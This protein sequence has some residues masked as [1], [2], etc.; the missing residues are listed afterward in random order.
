MSDH[1]GPSIAI[2][3][4]A[5]E[6]GVIGRDG[7]MPWH[8][9][10]ELKYFRARTIGKPVVMGRKTF[11]AIGKPLPGRENIVVTRDVS[12]ASPGIVTAPSLEA[13]LVTARQLAAARE[14]TE[15][16]I[17]GGADIYRQALSLAQRVYLT[18]VSMSP[19]GDATFPDL[20]PSAWRLI[21]ETPIPQGD[22]SE[23]R[24]TACVYDR[25]G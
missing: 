16:M 25:I 11:Q 8:L 4:A 21:E 19:D 2:I 1:S 22:P 7:K 23:V 14:A 3:V 20:S 12:F 13:A 24:A 9:P 17:I 10:S 5:A 6:N 18:R 15:I